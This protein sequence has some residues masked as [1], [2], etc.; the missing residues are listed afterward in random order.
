MIPGVLRREGRRLVQH[1][2]HSRLGVANGHAA[3]GGGRGLRRIRAG[4]RQLAL[5]FAA[6]DAVDRSVRL[7]GAQ[8]IPSQRLPVV[9]DPLVIARLRA[10]PGTFVRVPGSWRDDAAAP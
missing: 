4:A 8:P 2:L 7:L 9:F 5:D 3:H 1:L 6:A 10:L